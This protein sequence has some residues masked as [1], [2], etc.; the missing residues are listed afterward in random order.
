L[1]VRALIDLLRDFRDL[2]QLVGK[3]YGALGDL[4]RHRKTSQ[5]PSALPFSTPKT[6]F[7][8]ALTPHRSFAMTALALA[9]AKEIRKSLGGTL[10]DVVL[11]VC[12]GGLR[13][14][15]VDRGELPRK[16]LVAGVPVATN[17]DPRLE[18]NRVSNMFV[19]LPVDIEDPIERLRAIQASTTAAKEV[20][21]ILGGDMLA[22]WSQHT[23]PRLFAWFMRLYSRK[24]WASRH[25]PPIN[26]VVSNVPGPATPLSIVGARLD[27]LASVGPILEGIGLNITVWSYVGEMNFGIIACREM[28]PDPWKIADA[29]R[30]SLEELRKAAA[31][32][33]S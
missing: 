27:T 17:T 19:S 7:N 22:A 30:E 11:A 24:R 14:Y 4:R 32:S 8:G 12:A 25:R 31:T 9:E 23:P 20:H 18:G 16:P 28:V 15:L 2:P 1:F 6:S 21:S 3:T 26:L 13:R 5:Q 29:L 33:G 10:N